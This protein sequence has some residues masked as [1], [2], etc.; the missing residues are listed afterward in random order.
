MMRNKCFASA[1]NDQFKLFFCIFRANL[2]LSRFAKVLDYSKKSLEKI[3]EIRE[4][5]SRAVK[6]SGYYYL[7]KGKGDLGLSDIKEAIKNFEK[8]FDLAQSQAEKRLECL[9]CCSM[10]ALYLQLK[11]IEKVRRV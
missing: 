11:D 5:D 10:V 9:V 7:Y 4:T 8:S 6:L 2:N 3:N 1:I